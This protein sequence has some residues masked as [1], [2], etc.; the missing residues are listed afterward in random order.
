M[1]KLIHD[2]IHGYMDGYGSASC[3]FST[4]KDEIIKHHDDALDTIAKIQNTSD[5]DTILKKLIIKRN[6]T[7]PKIERDSI[8]WLNTLSKKEIKY[9]KWINEYYSDLYNH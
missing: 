5:R 9:I 6:N 3:Y 1:S 4:D 7:K 2:N 8:E